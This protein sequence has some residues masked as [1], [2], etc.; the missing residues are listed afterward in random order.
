[1][2]IYAL[3]SIIMQQDPKTRRRRILAILA[4][5]SIR[6]QSELADRLA[7]AGISANQATLSRDLRELGVVKGPDGYTLNPTS[8]PP[9]ELHAAIDQWLLD[10]IAAKNQVVLQT[11]PGGAQP[12]GLA[13]DRAHHELVVGT[14]AGDDT[15]L[16]ICKNERDANRLAGAILDNKT[17]TP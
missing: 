4:K 15:V 16:V 11:P 3:F 8:T 10:A 9:T 12:L 2:H 7:T 17:T 5:Q 6:S 13:L 1:M 14:V